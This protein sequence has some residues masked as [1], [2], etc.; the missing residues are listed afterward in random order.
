MILRELRIGGMTC[1]HCV[2]AVKREFAKLPAIRIKEVTIGSASIE[3]DET[4][5]T[6]DQIRAAVES[7]GYRITEEESR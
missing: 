2:M 1:N 6:E 7:A 3:F 4:S 5:I